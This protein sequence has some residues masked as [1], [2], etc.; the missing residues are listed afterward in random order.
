MAPEVHNAIRSVA[1]R[2][3]EEL[4]TAIDGRPK[5]EHDRITTAI[6]DK[7]AQQISALPTGKFGAK[8]WLSY[9]VM[10]IGKE[11]RC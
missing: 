4:L 11:Q 1:K 6:L 3:R 9:Y 8:S 2:C 10:L 5:S 7:Y